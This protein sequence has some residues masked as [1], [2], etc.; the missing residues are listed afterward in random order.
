MSESWRDRTWSIRNWR[1]VVWPELGVHP[2]PLQI[3]GR[4]LSSVEDQ[5][6]LGPPQQPGSQEAGSFQ[7]SVVWVCLCFRNRELTFI[8]LK[9]PISNTLQSALS[10]VKT[11]FAVCFYSTQQAPCRNLSLPSTSPQSRWLSPA[12]IHY[13][14]PVPEGWSRGLKA[15]APGRAVAGLSPADWSAASRHQ[16]GSLTAQPGSQATPR[17]KVSPPLLPSALGAHQQAAAT[18]SKSLEGLPENSG[19]VST[20]PSP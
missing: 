4:Q 12:A 6:L 13:P 2:P 7:R 14:T 18:G 16:P 9:H 1:G 5:P 3:S 10:F 11:H 15:A 20:V 8:S 17:A 19:C